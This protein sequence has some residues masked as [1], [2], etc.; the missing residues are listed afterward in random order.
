MK[1]KICLI[2]GA[3]SGIGKAAAAGLAELGATVVL[4]CRN[5]EKGERAISEIR[6]ET[7]NGELYS[8]PADL[9]SQKSVRQLA[10][11][12]RSQFQ[13]LHVLI[14]NAATFYTKLHYSVDGIEMQ[15]AVN[16]LSHFLLTNLLL[17][18]IKQSAPARII[19]VASNA[20]FGGK[21]NFDDLNHEKNYDG[22]RVYAQS[23]LANVLFTYELARRLEGTGVSANCLHPGVV[24][25]GIGNKH[26][27][28]IIKLGWLLWKP[29]MISTEKG[30]EKIIYLASSG[31]VEG[32]SG[33]YF[34]NCQAKSSSKLSCDRELARRLWTVSEKLTGC[35]RS[36][37]VLSNSAFNIIE[38]SL[39]FILF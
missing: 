34:E 4:T 27:S 20:H 38:K 2:T 22:R 1:N 6:K 26:S 13:Q 9:S 24:R 18:V 31:E 3:N 32:I 28:G 8:L 19:N 25:T 16:H 21:I 17:D 11:N 15:F 23:K 14:S 33:K 30:A 39:A 29:F 35:I 7:A 37:E 10:E 5:E 36:G 12:F